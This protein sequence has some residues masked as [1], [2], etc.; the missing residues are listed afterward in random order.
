MKGTSPSTLRG[1]SVDLNVSSSGSSRAGMNNNVNK[2]H[3]TNERIESSQNVDSPTEL[4]GARRSSFQRDLNREP[5]VDLSDNLKLEYVKYLKNNPGRSCVN[6]LGIRRYFQMNISTFE[7]QKDYNLSSSQL[8]ETSLNKLSVSQMEVF[9][10]R[11]RL[12]LKTTKNTDKRKFLTVLL[13]NVESYWV[14]LEK[15]KVNDRLDPSKLNSPSFTAQDN[16]K[17][18]S[19]ST[20]LISITQIQEMISQ[21]IAK[22]K[23][24]HP[25]GEAPIDS[26][27]PRTLFS[28]DECVSSQALTGHSSFETTPADGGRPKTPPR[29]QD[30]ISH[31]LCDYMRMHLKKP[32]QATG[33]NGQKIAH[34]LNPIPQVSPTDS[35]PSRQLPSYKNGSS[36]QAL[37][38]KRVRLSF[39]TTPAGGARPKT[40]PLYVNFPVLSSVDDASLNVEVRGSLTGLNGQKIAHAP[41]SIPPV[42]PTDLNCSRQLPSYDDHCSSLKGM[43]SPVRLSF[44]TTHATGGIPKISSPPLGKKPLNENLEVI[45]NVMGKRRKAV[46]YSD[47]ES[48]SESDFD[49]KREL[50]LKED[51]KRKKIV[52]AKI[53]E[54]AEKK[55]RESSAKQETLKGPVTGVYF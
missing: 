26:N 24:K 39:E 47:S 15:G 3:N 2:V 22:D 28:N 35:K 32:S 10:S 33:L 19:D 51:T 40:T 36:S 55:S 54:E 49:S 27:R 31:E 30:D 43:P 42:S 9:V 53:T 16:I 46:C 8:L 13:R 4:A 11:A 18:S 6:C 21:I 23:I 29:S 50:D 44:G 12:T 20:L 25:E 41:N 5:V 52:L 45:N 7:L 34:V 1:P 14:A 17:Y 37:T 38:G 48:D